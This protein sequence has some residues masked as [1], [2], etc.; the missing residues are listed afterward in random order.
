MR[1]A[2][3]LFL[4]VVWV[5][6]MHATGYAVPSKPASQQ[7]SSESAAKTVSGSE[8]PTGERNPSRVSEKGHQRSSASLSRATRPK[9]LANIRQRP[10]LGNAMT[11]HRPGSTQ[12][13]AASKDR[14]IR[15]EKPS[16]TR[17]VRPPGNI[18]AARA[19]PNS[20]R[21]R[22]SNPATVGGAAN[23]VPRN[24]GAI[25]GSRMTRKP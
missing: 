18:T 16:N 2:C 20:V 9:Q 11:V 13:A 4:T 7:S 21:H 25:N 15:N 22:G 17:S 23:S 10:R 5:S 19:S 14:S 12:S 24:S 3:L 6:W 8:K 1:T